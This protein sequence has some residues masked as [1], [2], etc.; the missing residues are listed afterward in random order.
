MTLE[1]R[2]CGARLGHRRVDSATESYGRRPDLPNVPGSGCL[3]YGTDEMVRF[4]AA[5]VSG[6]HRP[7]AGRAALGVRADLYGIVVPELQQV[8]AESVVAGRWP[9]P[10]RS[11]G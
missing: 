8:I 2:R 9:L 1:G 6:A 7:A 11:P 10:T 4:K 3:K 5:Y